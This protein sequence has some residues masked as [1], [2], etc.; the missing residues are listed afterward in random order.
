MSSP[1][2]ASRPPLGL[3]LAHALVFLPLAA[4]ALHRSLLEWR[5]VAE[6]LTRPA[7]LGALP[8]PAL[9]LALPLAT[10]SLFA[11]AIAWKRGRSAPLGASM[12]ALGA[13][14]LSLLAD[15]TRHQAVSVPE[16]NAALFTCA[17]SVRD[18]LAR[19]LSI[20]GPRLLPEVS[21][22]SAVRERCPPLARGRDFRARRPALRF[23]SEER[24]LPAPPMS[25]LVHRSTDGVRF[26]LH[27]V[28]ISADGRPVSLL[29][30]GDRPLWVRGAW[31]PA[32]EG[33][34][35]P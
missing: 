2:D 8:H 22:E 20:S 27:P 13:A 25:L 9:L 5:Q 7:H 17:E 23:V 1:S 30:G 35:S 26:S 34:G 10:A 12:A 29:G 19:E 32:G 18:A 21:F 4:L 33:P 15:P 31:R 24:P 28:G 16:A 6:A 3:R 11:I 14:G